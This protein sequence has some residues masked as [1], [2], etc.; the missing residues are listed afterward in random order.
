MTNTGQSCVRANLGVLE[1]TRVRVFLKNP[2]QEDWLWK[3][4]EGK[5]HTGVHPASG[6]AR[7][8]FSLRE[9]S[10]G[11]E[12]HCLQR[13]N[14]RACREEVPFAEGQLCW[15]GPGFLGIPSEPGQSLG[16]TI[17]ESLPLNLNWLPVS[18]FPRNSMDWLVTRP[19]KSQSWWVT[20]VH[21]HHR[22]CEHYDKEGKNAL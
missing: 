4:G 16:L 17:A 22:G 2:T 11:L 6:A 18:S 21:G 1:I 3:R 12:A 10:P 13:L 5:K 14:L 7:T 8:H 15:H 9:R 20:P 19:L